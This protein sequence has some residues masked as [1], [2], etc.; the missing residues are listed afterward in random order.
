MS[1]SCQQRQAV[2]GTVTGGGGTDMLSYA[3]YT[4]PVTVNLVTGVATGTA[5][6]SGI[7]NVTG[8]A[9]ND[10]ITGD[11]D[12][13]TIGGGGGTD[14]P[15]AAAGPTCSWSRRPSWPARGSPKPARPRRSA[16]RVG[17]RLDG[18]GGNAG[19][20]NGI[21]FTGVA[22]LVGSTNTDTFKIG[23][24]GSLTGTV[25]GGTGGRRQQARLLGPD[26]G[27]HGQPG[28]TASSIHGF[29]NI[30]RWWA[31]ARRPTS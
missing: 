18:H 17:Q 20:L 24:S 4:T 21:T 27:R 7:T 11:A 2:S 16:A 23:P 31:A 25:N 29:S 15:R 8:G 3:P 5:A 9:G 26:D 30:G 22:N 6:I 10:H 12:A 1:S 28:P 13:N 14:V 19:N